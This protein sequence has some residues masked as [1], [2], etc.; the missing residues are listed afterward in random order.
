MSTES[1]PTDR[2]AAI[3][4]MRGLVMILMATDHAAHVFYAEHVVLDSSVL[5]WQQSLPTIP[6]LH[7]WLSHM[8]API[9][10]FLAGTS[11]ALAASRSHRT[12]R[13]FDLDLVLRGALLIGIDLTFI[14]WIWGS[15]FESP[16]VLQVL[17]AIGAGMIAMV[18]LRRLPGPTTLILGI[19]LAGASEALAALPVPEVMR[20]MFLTGGF[21]DS[22]V[23]LYPVLPWLA[24]MLL[25]HGFGR[26]LVAGRSAN[27]FLVPA[28]AIAFATW[29]AIKLLDGYGNMLMTGSHDGALRWLQTSKYPPSLAFLGL[30]LGIGLGLLCALFSWRRT[31]DD[32]GL[33]MVLGQTALFFYVLHIALLESAG[34]LLAS[35]GYRPRGGLLGNSIAVILVV[36]AAWPL[37]LAFRALR[38]R[39][40]RSLLRLI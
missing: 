28:A 22:F 13:R 16:R 20:M 18:A 26:H 23:A 25:G 27:G 31:A 14:S 30:E 39:Y 12:G 32:R 11:I 17:F 10:V 36:L 8:C 29:F 5:P 3:D 7:R 1:L 19:L 35:L 2:I 40:P 4:Q 6:F 21:R 24:V 9:F 33:L 34:S 38:R 15:S 37:G